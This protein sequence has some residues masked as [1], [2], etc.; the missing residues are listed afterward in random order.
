M[1]AGGLRAGREVHW[2]A[3]DVAPLQQEATA[4]RYVLPELE[5]S[6]TQVH[7]LYNNATPI[8]TGSYP[9]FAEIRSITVQ[10]GQVLRLGR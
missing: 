9:A 2:D 5:R 4:C 10:A 8:V 6:G 7:S 1:Q 3:S